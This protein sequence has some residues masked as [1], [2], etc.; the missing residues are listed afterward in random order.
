[1]L[2]IQS[3]DLRIL[4]LGPTVRTRCTTIHVDRMRNLPV[5][6]TSTIVDT[7]V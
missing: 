2:G 1:M 3:R 5:T 6:H 7:V 4:I